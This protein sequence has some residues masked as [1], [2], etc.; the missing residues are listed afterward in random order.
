MESACLM[1]ERTLVIHVRDSHS[2]QDSNGTYWVYTIETNDTTSSLAYDLYYTLKL[3]FEVGQW[4]DDIQSFRS[5]T[6]H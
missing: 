1:E 6:R 5:C 3:T 2:V 4:T